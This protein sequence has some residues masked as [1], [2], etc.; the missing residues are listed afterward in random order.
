MIRKYYEY[1]GLGGGIDPKSTSN[2]QPMTQQTMTKEQILEKMVDE[3]PFTLPTA[4][5]PYIKEAMAI[6]AQQE[7]SKEREKA[8]KL[9]HQ[10]DMVLDWFENSCPNG[11]LPPYLY[12]KIKQS[13][14]EY[15]ATK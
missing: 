10:L 12:S 5:I 13:L 15:E 1:E 9:V 8:K 11:I 14:T 6:Y 4:C 3:M 2:A 7:V